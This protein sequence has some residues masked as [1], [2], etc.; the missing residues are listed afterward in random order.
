MDVRRL[1]HPS[2]FGAAHVSVAPAS[3][4]KIVMTH[5]LAKA[6][7][8]GAGEGI[9]YLIGRHHEWLHEKDWRSALVPLGAA[10]V[11]AAAIGLDVH[12]NS[13][14]RI[15]HSAVHLHAIGTAGLGAVGVLDGLARGY[16]AA[17]KELSSGDVRKLSDGKTQPVT[18]LWGAPAT[19]VG[20]EP[21]P[22]GQWLDEGG[23]RHFAGKQRQ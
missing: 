20:L 19:T 1:L 5:V 13:R 11:E 6:E 18:R 10:L 14:G 4:G 8:V 16:K 21:A 12:A 17:G 3:T 23:L 2:H 7:A 22:E 15:S 9:G